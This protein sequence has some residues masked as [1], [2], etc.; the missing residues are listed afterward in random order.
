MPQVSVNDCAYI[1]A[2]LRL[3][4]KQLRMNHERLGWRLLQVWSQAIA[5]KSLILPSALVGVAIGKPGDD[6]AKAFIAAQL[7]T[8]VKEDTELID[9][10]PM[11]SMF[12]ECDWPT[13][14]GDGQNLA[15]SSTDE[16]VN[17]QPPTTEER[18]VEFVPLEREESDEPDIIL[19]KPYAV[20]YWIVSRGESAA[21]ARTALMCSHGYTSE[22]DPCKACMRTG[23]KVAYP[24]RQAE[25]CADHYHATDEGWQVDWPLDI[26]TQLCI[27]H[28]D[29]VQ[30][31]TVKNEYVP[32]Y[33]T[34]LFEATP[35]E[36]TAWTERNDDL[37]P[38]ARGT[39]K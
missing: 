8:P 19:R 22:D 5:R 39:G 7:A 10:S 12:S 17:V 28:P 26:A 21:D 36:S 13:S 16:D 34:N 33:K 2:R 20:R 9:L 3:A 31:H 35:C 37:T 38:L 24:P 32:E 27:G 11:Q 25:M 15:A 23:V 18:S 29:P 6:V 1:D 30:V 14:P 4:G